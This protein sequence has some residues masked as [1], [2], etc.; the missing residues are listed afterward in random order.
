LIFAV[1]GDLNNDGKPDLIA[2]GGGGSGTITT[3]LMN[4]TGG[5]LQAPEPPQLRSPSNNATNVQLPA[6]FGWDSSARA[7]SYHLQV[8]LGPDFSFLVV[9]DSSVTSTS[10]QASALAY[11]NTYYWRVTPKGLAGK[12]ATSSPFSFR[13]AATSSIT[14]PV[15]SYSPNPTQSTE[16]KLISIP[17]TNPGA[18]SALV[19]G[20]GSRQEFDW[21]V[22]R[23]NGA[24]SNYLVEMSASEGL[25]VGQGYWL[26]RKN[27]LTLNRTD[28]ILPQLRSDATFPIP[29]QAGHNI[30]ANPFDKPVGWLNV[31]AAN[32]LTTPTKVPT[33][34]DASNQG[35]YDSS[36]VLQPFRGY[37]FVKP[38]GLDTLRVPYPFA[39]Q[40]SD[41]SFTK[42]IEWRLQLIFES[43]INSDVQN[44]IGVSPFA[45]TDRDDLDEHKPPL[46]FDQGF[47]YFPRPEWD[48]EVPRFSS[49]FRPTP[50][51]GQAWDFE[52]SNPRQVQSTIR[53]VGI[54]R[55]PASYEVVL[56]N[57][58]NSVPLN[59]RLDNEYAYQTVSE[60]MQFQLLVGNQSFVEHK[61]SQNL[62][63]QFALMQNYPNPFNPTTAISFALPREAHVKLEI[64]SL[65]GQRVKTLVDD[66]VMA[67]VHTYVWDGRGESGTNVASGMYVYRL[68]ADGRVIQ[69][70][71]LI[72]MK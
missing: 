55:I 47:L 1:A 3:Y 68:I 61:L 72:L 67:A 52:V 6:Q 8:A 9:N 33:Y 48:P 56:I 28:I 37:Y 46:V 27:S 60:K 35:R 36:T 12:G 64:Y 20:A 40:N 50:G 26:I 11:N 38:A 53:F 59:L 21:R 24:P 22:F 41:A 71:K 5:T 54:E 23:D 13:T 69:S 34:P 62:P 42:P 16:Y 4:T 14:S 57:Q 19:A 29:L 7:T 32:A 31:L 63:T 39:A 66:R 65:L 58:H 70:R 49:D 18:V 44:F 43:D 45:L 17:G 51:E 25:N 15:F 10:F 2:S 30:I